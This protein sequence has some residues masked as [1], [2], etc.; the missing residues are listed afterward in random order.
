MPKSMPEVRAGRLAPRDR[1]RSGGRVSDIRRVVDRLAEGEGFGRRPSSA[2]IE[3]MSH[4]EEGP[5]ETAFGRLRRAE[6]IGRPLA[7]EDFMSRLETLTGRLLAP[8]KR[9]PKPRGAEEGARGAL[10]SALSPYSRPWRCFTVAT[11]W[12][13]WE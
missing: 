2:I 6:S 8:K 9:G 10:F 11:A 12:R 7:D 13:V 4:V 3:V 5:D 1:G